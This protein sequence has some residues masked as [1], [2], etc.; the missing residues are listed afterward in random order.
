MRSNRTSLIKS[1][2]KSQNINNDIEKVTENK[3]KINRNKK[4]SNFRNILNEEELKKT[5]EELFTQRDI[6]HKSEEIQEN[7][8]NVRNER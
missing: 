3:Q 6:K 8:K 7:L 4:L 5:Q 2:N 1:T